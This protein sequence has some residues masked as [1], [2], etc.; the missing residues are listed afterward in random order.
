MF[1][2]FSLS[3]PPTDNWKKAAVSSAS[4]I[5]RDMKSPGAFVTEGISAIFP[6]FR[7]STGAF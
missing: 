4:I 2:M 5:I 3:W 7:F 6:A 1:V